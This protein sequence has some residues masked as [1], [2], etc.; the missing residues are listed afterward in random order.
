MRP[1]ARLV[2]G[3]RGDLRGVQTDLAKARSFLPERDSR[4]GKS[5]QRKHRGMDLEKVKDKVAVAHGGSRCGNLHGEM[6]LSRK[7][8]REHSNH[9]AIDIP[10]TGRY[11][12]F[13]PVKH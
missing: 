11:T 1:E 7:L 6:R 3:L 12:L 13:E 4:S 5:D 8:K 9:K 2:S 10:S